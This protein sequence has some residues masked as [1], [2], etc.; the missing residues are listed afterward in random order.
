MAKYRIEISATAG[1]QIRRLAQKDQIAIIRRIQELERGPR[2]RQLR[3]F[4]GYDDVYRI[5]VG[6]YRILYGVEGTKLIVIVLKV[7]HRRDVYR[8]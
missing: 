4:A 6:N 5:R 1:K 8:K 2:P 7:G 3:K